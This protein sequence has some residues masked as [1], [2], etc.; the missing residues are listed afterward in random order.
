MYTHTHVYIYIYICIS[1]GRS[2][3]I[4]RSSIVEDHKNDASLL[5]TQHY[6]VGIKGEWSI[7][8]KK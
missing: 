2:G 5:N 7:P 4:P 3:F 8:G 1:S 6:N